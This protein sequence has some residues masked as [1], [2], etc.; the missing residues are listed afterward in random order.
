MSFYL[1]IFLLD[2]DIIVRL[3]LFVALL[4]PFHYEDIGLNVWHS[5]EQ[6]TLTHPLTSGVHQSKHAYVPKADILNTCGKLIYVDTHRNS[7]ACEQ[8]I[9]YTVNGTEWPYMC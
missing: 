2:T 5:T 7:I 4:M 3:F 6:R 9:I 8:S 1:L